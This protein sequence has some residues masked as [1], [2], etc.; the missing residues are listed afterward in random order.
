MLLE[1]PELLTGRVGEWAVYGTRNERI[2]LVGRPK[3]YEG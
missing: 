1:R 3:S 2:L